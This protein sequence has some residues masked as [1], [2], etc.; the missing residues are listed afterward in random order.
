MRSQILFVSK[1]CVLLIAM[2]LVFSEALHGQY[3]SKYPDIPIVDVH[4]HAGNTN[5]ATNYVKVSEVLKAKNGFDLAFWVALTDP[6]KDVAEQM[7]KASGNRMLFTA[8]QMRPHQGL[9]ITAEEVIDKVRNDGYI[10]MKLWFGPHYRVLK[11]GED[12]F[13]K[14]DDPR[15]EPFFASLEKANV[16]MT[17]LHIADPNQV[18]GNRGEWLKDPVYFWQQIR[19]FE[20]VIAKHPDLTIVAAHGSW[21]VCQDAQI[22]YLRY[23]LS[24]YPNFYVDTAATCQY[25]HLVDRE[26]LRDFY[27][28]YQDRILFGTDVSRVVHDGAVNYI[29]GRYANFFAILE[30]DQIVNGSFFGDETTKG[31]DLPREVLE[32][33]YYKN[34]QK[35]YP[36]LKEA[37]EKVEK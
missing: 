28:E 30:T 10:G 17:S 9:T 33:V 26:N 13:T 35:L 34:A 22:D 18:F 19:A 36:Y 2:N 8:S 1:L 6:G 12:G 3:Q 5:D 25:V 29:A 31:L 15:L 20:N 27:I 32:K 11:E 4:T 23:M 14:L 16:L 21:L 37:M 7:K 24:T